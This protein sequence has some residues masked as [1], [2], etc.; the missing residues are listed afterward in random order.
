V[1]EVTT[2][3]AVL[4]ELGVTPA[5][6]AMIIRSAREFDEHGRWVSFDTLAYEA[7]EQNEEW[8]PWTPSTLPRLLGGAW[9]G[10][11]VTLTPLG[12]LAA[13]SA[14][15]TVAALVEIVRI[16]AQ[17]KIDLR[18][19]AELGR[20]ILVSEYGWSDA[21]ATRAGELFQMVPGLSGG[22]HGGDDW[23]LMIFRGALQ[24]R[25][26]DTP[27][28]LLGVLMG[29]ADQDRKLFLNH[30]YRAPQVEPVGAGQV[31]ADV[32]GRRLRRWFARSETAIERPWV[33]YVVLPLAVAVISGLILLLLHA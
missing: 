31:I 20:D 29:L 14:P 25:N 2:P 4:D 9:T 26:V 15:R 16:S 28:D 27:A 17:R 23:Q 6:K 32:S 12:L 1:A 3:D 24:Y 30:A 5:Q 18:D 10:E 11:S 13:G 8:D 21:A 19:V 22:G 33:K 7:A